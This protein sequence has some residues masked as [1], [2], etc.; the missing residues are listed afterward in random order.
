MFERLV[1]V[2]LVSLAAVWPAAASA[3]T[4]PDKP[5]RL[6]VPFAPGGTN[7]IV[8]RMVGTHLNQ[9]LGQPVIVDNR[10]GAEA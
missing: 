2:L 8:A 9:T 3:Q 4:Y 7:D 5:I 10:P 6:I 1:H